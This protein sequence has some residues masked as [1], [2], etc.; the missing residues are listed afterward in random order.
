VISESGETEALA[1]SVEDSNGVYFVPALAGLSAPYHDPYARGTIFGI[2]RGTKKAH[3]VRAT[4][5]GIAFRLKDIMDVVEKESGVKMKAIRI[6]GGASKNN[7]L[8]QLMADMMDV[9]VDRPF[10]VEATSLGAAEMAGLFIGMW[11]EEDF[12]AA[13]T[14]EKTF[15]PEISDEKQNKAYAGWQE[16][17]KR[18]M[19]WNV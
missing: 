14:I 4:L 16:A 13:L 5:E 2:T 3:L 9:Q 11:K 1:R 18:S 6:D 19:N 7:L 10:S 15:T 8:A 17:I 12:E